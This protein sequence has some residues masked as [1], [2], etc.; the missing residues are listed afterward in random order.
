MKLLPGRLLSPFIVRNGYAQQTKDPVGNGLCRLLEGSGVAVEGRGGREDNAAG[1]RDRFH[2]ID[3]YKI[4]RR[5][6]DEADELFPFLQH[7]VRGPCDEGIA[8]AL[9]DTTQ[10]AHAAGADDQRV[11]ARATGRERG[12]II[13]I[14]IGFEFKVL[15]TGVL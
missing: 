3:M 6:P 4:I 11:K 15:I 8:D 2:I 13:F 10:C 1:F 7:H 14:A 9:G 5:L 12:E